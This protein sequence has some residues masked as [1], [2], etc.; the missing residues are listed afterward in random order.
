M[1]RISFSLFSPKTNGKQFCFSLLLIWWTKK[2]SSN[3]NE[4]DISLYIEW[5]FLSLSLSFYL[6]L[7]KKHLNVSKSIDLIT[8]IF[9]AF[10]LFLQTFSCGF[11][12]RYY[13]IHTASHHW[14]NSG[15]ILKIEIF[16]FYFCNESIFGITVYD[17]PLVV[18]HFYVCV[19][20]GCQIQNS[21]TMHTDK[22]KKWKVAL[23]HY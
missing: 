7:H 5:K 20:I 18:V 10:A 23:H 21:G 4:N 11:L 3:R 17:L 6:T 19:C 22:H 1:K 15:F 2:F 14:F 8:I 16:N 9:T 13:R 12:F